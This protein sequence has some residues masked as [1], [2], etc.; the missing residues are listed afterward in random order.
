MSVIRC[1]ACR[2]DA[3]QS[4]MRGL[5]TAGRVFESEWIAGLVIERDEL[6]GN[7]IAHSDF[8]GSLQDACRHRQYSS[9]HSV[10]SVIHDGQ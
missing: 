10:A 5:V 3:C 9:G 1:R 2:V 4:D 8:R 6:Q 7:V